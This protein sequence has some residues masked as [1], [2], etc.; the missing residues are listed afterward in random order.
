MQKTPISGQH[1]DIL[2]ISTSCF[3]VVVKYDPLSC[4]QDV[5]PA[6]VLAIMPEIFLA[7]LPTF[8]QS[9]R[10]PKSGATQ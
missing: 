9:F 8:R 10:H 1:A 2:S 5:F 3:P 6:F 7:G 4:F